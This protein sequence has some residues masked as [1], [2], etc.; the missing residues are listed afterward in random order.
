MLFNFPIRLNCNERDEDVAVS[1][2][3]VNHGESKQTKEDKERTVD[4]EFL[5][6]S[7]LK[8][9]LAFRQHN[10]HLSVNRGIWQLI[11]FF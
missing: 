2:G 6:S 7:P 5:Q 11:R 9:G 4:Q 10:F 3:K 1:N 8:C